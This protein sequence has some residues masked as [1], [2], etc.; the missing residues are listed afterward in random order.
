MKRNDGFIGQIPFPPRSIFVDSEVRQ[1]RMESLEAFLIEVSMSDLEKRNRS[2]L[3]GFLRVTTSG[4]T[5]VVCKCKQGE[6]GKHVFEIKITD[7]DGK[8]GSIE[9]RYSEFAALR[10]EIGDW[11]KGMVLTSFPVKLLSNSTSALRERRQSLEDWLT[12]INCLNPMPEAVESA[13]FEFLG[14]TSFG[15]FRGKSSSPKKKTVA[16]KGRGGGGGE[17]GRRASALLIDDGDDNEGHF[18]DQ[19]MDRVGVGGTLHEEEEKGQGGEGEEG[20][21]DEGGGGAEVKEKSEPMPIVQTSSYEA[22]SDDACLD[23]PP[24]APSSSEILSESLTSSLGTAGTDSLP[25]SLSLPED[26]IKM[27]KRRSSVTRSIGKKLSKMGISKKKL[28]GKKKGGE[29]E[30]EVVKSVNDLLAV[31]ESGKDDMKSADIAKLFEEM[32]RAPGNSPDTARIVIAVVLQFNTKINVVLSGCDFLYRHTR[33]FPNVDF[34]EFI[35][36]GGVAILCYSIKKNF[37]SKEHVANML[38]MLLELAEWDSDGFKKAIPGYAKQIFKHS[39]ALYEQGGQEEM[40]LEKLLG[41][42]GGEGGGAEGGE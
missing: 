19:M 5:A 39:K 23:V 40:R 12:Q 8:V 21:G 38:E 27:T 18:F 6:E 30:G 32:V 17:K 22:Q 34:N 26:N 13:L 29:K 41:L 24:P 10:K 11:I 42:I 2:L 33:K 25:S 3:Q 37:H 14:L 20:G 7:R 1:K 16:E 28:M 15:M 9:K 31:M 36:M 35:Q 4:V